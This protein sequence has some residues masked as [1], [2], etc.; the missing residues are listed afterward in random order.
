MNRS[1]ILKY[2]AN[3]ITLKYEILWCCQASQTNSVSFFSFE[4]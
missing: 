1:L 2:K 4:A 3:F